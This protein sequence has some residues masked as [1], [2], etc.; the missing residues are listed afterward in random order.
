MG[1][2]CVVIFIQ[3][4]RTR[5][6]QKSMTKGNDTFGQGKLVPDIKRRVYSL[7]SSDF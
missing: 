5:K 3:F 2:F 6:S 7:L 1:G 4:I